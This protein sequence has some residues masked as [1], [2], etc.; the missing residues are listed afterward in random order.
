MNTDPT[1]NAPVPAAA[2]DGDADWLDAA[3]AAD[4]RTHREAYIDDSGFTA[5][6]TAALP[7]PATLPAWRKPALSAL[8]AA[9]GLGVALALPT[10]ATDVA[11]E[12][13]RLAAHPVSLLEIVTAIAVLGALSWGGAAYVLRQD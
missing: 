3:L 13:F 2:S 7:A 4:G 1:M 9:A 5:H 12:L 11:R 6:L 10:A 8:W